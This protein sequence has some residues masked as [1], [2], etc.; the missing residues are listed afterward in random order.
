LNKK[1]VIVQD[2]CILF[3]LIKL[4]LI[5]D[6]FQLNLDVFTTPHVIAEITEESQLT[7][8][9]SYITDGILQIDVTGSYEVIVSIFNENPGLSFA[10]SSVLELAFR[11]TGIILSSDRSL[12]NKSEQRNITVRGIVWLIE[13]LSKEEILSKEKAISKLESYLKLNCRAPKKEINELINKLRNEIDQ[14]EEEK[15][16]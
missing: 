16:I 15:R 3:D 2:S 13:S 1:E 14:Q 7:E 5:N 12:R 4:D 6:F 11:K 8:I 9:T 10:D